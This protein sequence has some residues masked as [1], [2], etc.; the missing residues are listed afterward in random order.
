MSDLK[1]RAKARLEGWM[2]EYYGY[3][4]FEVVG[5]TISGISGLLSMA[6]LASYKWLAKDLNLSGSLDGGLITF[7]VYRGNATWHECVHFVV[8]NLQ[9]HSFFGFLCLFK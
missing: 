9:A 4:L 5:I 2:L 8:A 3:S 1:N 6:T 7:G